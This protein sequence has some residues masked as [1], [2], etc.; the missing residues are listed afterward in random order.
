MNAWSRF[1]L[2]PSSYLGEGRGTGGGDLEE[3]QKKF[4]NNPLG[5]KKNSGENSNFAGKDPKE[6]VWEGVILHAGSP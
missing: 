1:H 5:R 2:F 3:S 6:V 4:V